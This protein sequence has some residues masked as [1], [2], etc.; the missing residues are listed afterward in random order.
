MPSVVTGERTLGATSS[1]LRVNKGS[2][3]TEPYPETDIRF[4]YPYSDI[5]TAKINADFSINAWID[6]PDFLE[7]EG[8]IATRLPAIYVNDD[9]YDIRISKTPRAGYHLHPLHVDVATGQ[10][11]DYVWIGSDKSVKVLGENKLTC[12]LGEAYY[13]SVREDTVLRPYSEAVGEGWSQADIALRDYLR[14]LILIAGASHNTQVVFGRGVCDLRY[15]NSDVVTVASTDENYV[16]VSDATG[17]LY[18]EDEWVNLGTTRGNT[19]IFAQ[20]KIVLIEA[21]YDSLGNTRITVD[22]AIFSTTVGN[23]LW[24][25]P[26]LISEE[27]FMAMGNECGYIGTDG[28][29]P[30]SF[31]GIWNLWGNIWEWCDGF[32]HVDS[33]PYFTYDPSKYSLIGASQ[34]AD[35][36][37]FTQHATVMPSSNGYC[38][39]FAGEPAVPS[40]LSGGS[41]SA[42]MCDYFYTS[43]GYK[44]LRVGGYLSDGSGD[45]FFN[46]DVNGAPSGAVWNVGSRLLGRP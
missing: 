13:T 21:N 33:V 24:H 26:Q 38:G 28:R 22:G 29:V 25:A 37:Q 35:L 41:D 16:I 11:R 42:G 6:E 17:A 1:T 4:K 15:N 27:D 8:I 3:N 32:F 46:W 18:N 43:T 14:I 30:V 31:F 9:L 10:K 34:P 45:G 20:R 44:A 40:T 19:S 36:S 23:V 2:M 12:A 7:A 5:R 39:E